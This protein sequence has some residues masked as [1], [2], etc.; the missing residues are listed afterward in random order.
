V[1]DIVV[2]AVDLCKDYRVRG[3]HETLRAVDGV[4]FTLARGESLAIVGESGS[5]KSTVANMVMGLLE[6]TSGS[7]AISGL[8]ADNRMKRARERRRRAA[9]IQLVFQ[10]PY[11]SLDPRQRVG[12]A[13]AEVMRLHGVAPEGGMEQG[14][15][16]LMNDVGLDPEYA[17]S[18]PRALSGGQR[19]RVAIARAL[20]AAPDVIVLDEAVSALDVTVQAHVLRLLDRIRKDKQVSY[21]FISHDL[22]VVAEVSDR[23]LVMSRGTVV[24]AGATFDVLTEPTHPYTKALVAS[25]PR[26]GWKPSEVVRTQL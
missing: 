24:E 21:I 6:P 4:S 3:K 18:F 12:D 2:T 13:L 11:S 23:V 25:V 1:D 9:R 10:D 8:P 16:A 5:G 26:P 22:A 7:V 20:A 14:V 15:A 19:Q 17:S